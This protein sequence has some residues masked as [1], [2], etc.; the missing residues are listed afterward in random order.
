MDI[1]SGGTAWGAVCTHVSVHKMFRP[2]GSATFLW[3]P[4]G[5]GATPAAW[6]GAPRFLEL[7]VDAD[8]VS[9]QLQP[10]A[11]ARKFAQAKE[12]LDEELLAFS[13]EADL[14]VSV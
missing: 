10:Q 1:A 12:T 4:R 6:R 3:S 14:Y 5:W 13:R 9:C 11:L 8:V 2:S 7:R